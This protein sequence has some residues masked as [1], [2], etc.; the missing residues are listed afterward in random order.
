MTSAVLDFARALTKRDYASAYAMTSSDYQGRVP[1]D[2]M[3]AAFDAIVPD[4]FGDV[5]SVQIVQTMDDWPGKQPSDAGWAYV[6]IGG[7][8]YSEALTVVV[9][10]EDGSLKVRDVE[11]GRP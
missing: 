8:V 1:L 7:D 5:T 4:D 9:T 6:S 10:L 2:G 3:R 11:F